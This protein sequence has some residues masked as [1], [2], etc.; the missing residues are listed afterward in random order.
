MVFCGQCGLQLSPGMTRCPRCGTM[1]EIA[2]DNNIEPLQADAPTIEATYIQRP[3]VTMYPDVPQQSFSAT[4]PDSQKLILHASSNG[5]YSY[6]P[7]SGNEQT[8][9]M[10]APD[11]HPHASAPIDFQVDTPY[12][13]QPNSVH[14]PT[15]AS[16]IYPSQPGNYASPGSTYAEAI[17]PGGAIPSGYPPQTSKKR[18]RA[19]VALLVVVA[20]LLVLGIGGFFVV[21]RSHLFGN[22]VSPVTNGAN[23]NGATTQNTPL[24]PTEQAKVVVQHYYSAINNKNYPE[25]YGLWRWGANGPT[26]AAFENGYANT[27]H[28]NLT[29]RNATPLSDGTVKVSLVVVATE[30]V[31]GVIKHHTYAGYYIVGQDGGT[32]KIFRGYLSRIK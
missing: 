28:D 27:E 18:G 7:A 9:A 20:L 22:P 31:N 6:T 16:M 32:W 2:A 10:N 5:N 15:A 19:G 17:P 26:L 11:Y 4:P 12:S 23:G 25:A 3:Q 30:R 13:T 29:I 24:T 8:S 21:Q 1:T 14:Y